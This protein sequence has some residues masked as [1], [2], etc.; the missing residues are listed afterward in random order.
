VIGVAAIE[1]NLIALRGTIEHAASTAGRDASDVTI[2]AVTKGFGP[3]L[4]GR[5]VQAGL[6]DLGESYAQEL[7]RKVDEVAV[8]EL[9]VALRWHFIGNLQRNK[10]KAIAPHVHLWHSV[11]RRSLGAEIAKHAPGAAVLAQLNLSGESG[12]GGGPVDET[13]SLVGELRALG[14][15]VR[16]LMGVG[17]AGPPE[18]SRPGFRA[19]V[20]LADALD[21]PVRSIGMSGDVAVAV[22]EGATMVRVGSGLFGP[23]PAKVP[24]P[25]PS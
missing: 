11:D 20:A 10:V 13:E 3:E 21:L 8:D 5:A 9:S 4:I 16:G 1:S 22:E 19:L 15:D 24:A 6:E 2:V 7:L 17:P 12:K 18:A 23:R 25:A 14:L